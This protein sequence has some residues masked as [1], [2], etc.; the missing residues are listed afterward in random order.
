MFMKVFLQKMSLLSLSLMLV[1][2]FSTSTALPQMLATFHR[3]GYTTSQV[4]ILFSIPS[5][6]IMITLILTPW[7][8]RILPERLTIIVGLLLIAFGGS[9]PAIVPHY[10]M[11]VVSRLLLGIGIGLINTYA[12]SIISENFKGKERSQMLGFRGSFEVLGNAFLTILVGFLVPISWSL[13]FIV[14]LLA[15]PILLFYILFSPRQS[16]NNIMEQTPK[17]PEKLPKDTIFDIVRLSL[18]AGFV[19][20][21][22]STNSLR[23]PI[24][25]EQLHLGNSQQTSFI[26]SGMMLM[27]I[28]SGMCFERLL[29]SLQRYLVSFS[30]LFFAIGELLIALS[31]HSVIILIGAMLSGFWY[32]IVVTSV[33]N[34]ISEKVTPRLIGRSTTLIL[35]FCNLGG[36]SA[37][38][39]LGVFSQF[40]PHPTLAFIIY[41]VISFLISFV[42]MFQTVFL[43]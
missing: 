25:I 30:L 22:N 29:S 41:A 40:N 26:L 38:T 4:D 31:Q 9:L 10:N 43:D 35:L 7:L 34:T 1:S 42:L 5:L 33:F 21:V 20:L 18:L 11:I 17:S 16:K 2:T 13:A 8:H 32:S 3:Q 28:F 36:A 12:I 14:Y 37:A 19:I 27:G 6:M 24:I 23:I 39:V 15:L